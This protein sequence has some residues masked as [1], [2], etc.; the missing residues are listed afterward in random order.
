M[1]SIYMSFE[2]VYSITFKGT[3][4]TTKGCIL[5]LTFDMSCKILLLLKP[6]QTPHTTPGHVECL[7]NTDKFQKCTPIYNLNR[8]TSFA[9]PQLLLLNCS[10]SIAP[11]Q[12]LLLNCSSSI[13]PPQ[14]L[15]LNC[16]T[17]HYLPTS[18]TSTQECLRQ[19]EVLGPKCS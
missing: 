5:M 4:L 3:L 11:P 10:S 2:V 12:L 17:Q 7:Y 18:I 9:P 6:V 1:F 13:A 19:M 14:L 16:F 8:P 15:L